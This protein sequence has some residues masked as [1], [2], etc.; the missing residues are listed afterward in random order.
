MLQPKCTVSATTTAS[1]TIIMIVQSIAT[2]HGRRSH[3]S[4]NQWTKAIIASP[5]SISHHHGRC[6]NSFTTQSWR[7]CRP[8]MSQFRCSGCLPRAMTAP[9]HQIKNKARHSK[10]MSQSNRPSPRFLLGKAHFDVEATF[11]S[12]TWD[13]RGAVGAGD[14][15]DD[16]QAKSVSVGVS[17]A[18]AAELLEG[19]EKTLDLAWWDHGS[20]VLHRNACLSCGRCRRYLDPASGRVV[21][22]GVVHQVRH[23]AR[24]QVRV[25]CR[26]GCCERCVDVEASAL[27]F[28]V[29]G[30]DDGP[31]D[32]G[33]VKGFPPLDSPFAACQCEQ[34]LDEA[35]LLFAE[36]QRV[37][38]G[39]SQR[40]GGGVWI[41][42]CHLQ[43]GPL[44]GERGS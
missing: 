1:T 20:G 7:R 27:G 42:E 37:L 17:D 40:L 4:M 3:L 26:R 11:G 24:D 38:A 13:E 9:P 12:G 41:G 6:S 10:P 35:F 14:G 21:A 19:L 31:G 36:R 2:R 32:V 43:Q 8:T 16:G 18:L 23:Q 34:R 39:G 44:G 33:E 30:Q 25:T 28:L 5:E 15:A 29:A 22:Q